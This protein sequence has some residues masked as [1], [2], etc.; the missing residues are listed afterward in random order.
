MHFKRFIDQNLNW[1][2]VN[3]NSVNVGNERSCFQVT[4]D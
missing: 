2:I 4:V 3:Q 1:L